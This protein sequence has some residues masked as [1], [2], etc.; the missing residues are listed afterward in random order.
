VILGA[1]H[2]GLSMSR[3]L[4]EYSID[5]VVLE[6][7]EVANSWRQERW[8]SLR[9]LTPNW[10]NRLPGY[11]YAGSDP[12]AFMDLPEVVNFISRFAAETSA[13]VRTHTTVTSVSSVDGEYQVVTEHGE[14]RCR[15]VVLATGATNSPRVPDCIGTCRRRCSA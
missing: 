5:Y 3:V 15:T 6:R 10:L 2:A 14:F 9:L 7:G 11:A 12:D 8:D 4:T 13:P 1:G